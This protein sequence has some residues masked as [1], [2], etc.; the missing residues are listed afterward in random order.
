MEKKPQPVVGFRERLK[1]IS[2]LKCVDVAV[3]QD[4]YSPIDNVKKIRPDILMESDSHSEEDMKKVRKIADEIGCKV[5][6]MPYYPE[7]SST[8]IKEKIKNN[9]LSIK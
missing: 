5:M 9:G 8:K 3:A 7:Q 1:I 6:V 4:T 2:S